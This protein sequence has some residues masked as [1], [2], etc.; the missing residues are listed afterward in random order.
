MTDQELISK[1]KSK[2]T[3]QRSEIAR[4]IRKMEALTTEK[5]ALLRDVKWMRGE[6]T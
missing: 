1:L 3:T 2:I 5:S 4:L 6:K